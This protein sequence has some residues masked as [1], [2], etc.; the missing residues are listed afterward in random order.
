MPA[1]DTNFDLDRWGLLSHYC[2][3]DLCYGDGSA[4]QTWPDR[5]GYADLVSPTAAESPTLVYDSINMRRAVLFDGVDDHYLLG[6]VSSHQFLHSTGGAVYFVVRPGVVAN[7]DAQY[8]LMSSAED[9]QT[10]GQTGVAF[11]WDDRSSVPVNETVRH[12]VVGGAANPLVNLLAPDASSAANTFQVI[13]FL[14]GDLTLTPVG[15]GT[16]EH[17]KRAKQTVNGT[18]LLPAVAPT[19]S[20]SSGL[21]NSTYPLTVGARE[22]GAGLGDFL[23]G[24]IAEILIY[25][26][27]HSI[28]QALAISKALQGKYAIP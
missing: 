20:A 12:R 14:N 4:I 9:G 26:V 2:A 19:I 23:A 3:G 16:T 8:A 21:T 27:K 10:V 11:L 7:P 5:E 1:Y 28:P 24:E 17:R 18:Q 15:T 6:T 25:N 13:A 22:T